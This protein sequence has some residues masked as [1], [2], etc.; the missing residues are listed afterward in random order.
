MFSGLGLEE[1]N[2]PRFRQ[3]ALAFMRG[4]YYFGSA[5]GFRFARPLC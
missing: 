1:S 4:W 2:V 5:P 3:S